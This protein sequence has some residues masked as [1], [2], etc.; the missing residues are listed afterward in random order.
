MAASCFGVLSEAESFVKL[1]A[2]VMASGT[3]NGSNNSPGSANHNH[4]LEYLDMKSS[5]VGSTPFDPKKSRVTVQRPGEQKAY[6]CGPNSRKNKK[7]DSSVSPC[8]VSYIVYNWFARATI[9]TVK[10]SPSLSTPPLHSFLPHLDHIRSFLLATRVSLSPASAR[11]A[12]T[13]FCYY[14]PWGFLT[15]FQCL[16][17]QGVPQWAACYQSRAR[18][19]VCK[20]VAA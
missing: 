2:F 15:C 20:I 11:T 3:V 9:D 19:T 13:A 14:M 17:P 12:G 8:P 16:D 7:A 1:S 4:S 6:Q 18:T 5:L 10:I